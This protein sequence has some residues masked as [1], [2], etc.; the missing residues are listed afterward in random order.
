M[1]EIKTLIFP[2]VLAIG[3]SF[4]SFLTM[5]IPRIYEKESGIFL[6]RSHCRFCKKTLRARDLIPIASY[7][8]NRGKCAFCKE[9]IST[10]Y[11]TIEISTAIMFA[12]IYTKF[13]FENISGIPLTAFYLTI[14]FALIF[15]FFYDIKYLEISDI[16]L[17]PAIALGL[18]KSFVTDSPSFES[19]LIGGLIGISFFLIQILLSKGKW[20]GAGDIRIGALMGILLG[21]QMTL[22]ALVISYVIGSIV[23][24]GL[25]AAKQKEIGGKIALGPFL[26][27]GTFITLFFGENIINWYLN[28]FL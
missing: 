20:V 28:L 6:G 3:I 2:L 12:L 7:L 15:T 8:I 21:W 14:S 25:L 19:A 13:P 24:I 10:L 16:I 4:G 22:T 9:K 1:T 27:S 5:L 26:V 23:S 17:L 18:I 11:P